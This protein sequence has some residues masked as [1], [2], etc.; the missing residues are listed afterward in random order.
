MIFI[1]FNICGQKIGNNVF[2][3][4]SSKKWFQIVAGLEILAKIEHSFVRPIL[5]NFTLQIMSHPLKLWHISSV[6]IHQFRFW[7]PCRHS[8]KKE[9]TP[10]YILISA[11]FDLSL[12]TVIHFTWVW[13]GYG[14]VHTNLPHRSSI[15][16][17]LWVCQGRGEPLA[18]QIRAKNRA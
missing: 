15:V 17:K 7:I 13:G 10:L 4:C 1:S 18:I 2:F 9:L 8:E 3:D 12:Y 16:N 14:S 11:S 5:I 6:I